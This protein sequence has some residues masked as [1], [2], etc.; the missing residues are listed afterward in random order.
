MGNDDGWTRREALHGAGAVLLAVAWRP[1]RADAAELEAAIRQW[2]GGTPVREGRVHFEVAP[3]VD[4]GNTVPVSVEVDSPMSTTDHVSAI[5]LFNESNPLRDIARFRLGPRC[6][7]A[8]VGTRIRLATSQKLVAVA[9][10]SDGSC[11]SH[12]VEVVVTL[13]SCIE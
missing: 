7:R 11:W 4:N 8:R 1:A 6:G 13:A 5:A 10:L 12:T 2:S 3:L 9:R